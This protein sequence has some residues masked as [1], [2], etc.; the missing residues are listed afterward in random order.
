MLTMTRCTHGS[1]VINISGVFMI[2]VREFNFF[3]YL[4]TYFANFWESKFTPYP[5]ML[6]QIAGGISFPFRIIF[7][8]IFTNF[9]SRFRDDP[10][11]NPIIP[12]R[13][14]NPGNSIAFSGTKFSI[15]SFDFTRNCFKRFFT[16]CTVYNHML[17]V[18]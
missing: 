2:F 12:G 18:S 4:F 9:E 8:H 7:T 11:L 17:N 14:A 6:S 10:G 16:N 1:V 5:I 13:F 15:L 3:G